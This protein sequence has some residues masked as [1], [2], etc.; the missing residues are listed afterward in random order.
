MIAFSIFF[1]NI[2][3]LRLFLELDFPSLKI[4]SFDTIF[5]KKWSDKI[6]IRKYLYKYRGG[7]VVNYI[8]KIA[9]IRTVE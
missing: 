8:H 4:I 1:V 5:G 3:R 6:I 2:L 9:R 7:F